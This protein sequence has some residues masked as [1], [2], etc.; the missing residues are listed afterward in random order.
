MVLSLL[1]RLV[2][3][4]PKRVLLTVLLLTVVAG[5]FGATVSEH[6]SAAGF[7]DPGSPSARGVKILTEKYSQGDMDVTLVVRAPGWV[8]D[9]TAAVAGRQPVD[10]LRNSAHVGHVESPARAEG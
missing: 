10:Q 7:Q 3:A 8:L 9:Q 6:L 2:I 4:V 5:G 1:T